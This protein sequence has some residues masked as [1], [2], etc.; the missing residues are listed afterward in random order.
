M[1]DTANRNYPKP[2][3]GTANVATEWQRIADALDLLD[4]DV[5][6]VL[7][8]L[9]TKA[10]LIH[11]HAIGDV[12]GLGAALASK[13]QG[14]HKHGLG[15][16]SDVDIVGAVLGQIFTMGENGKFVCRDPSAVLGA[17]N[18]PIGGV[19]GLQSALDAR[20]VAANDLS[21]LISAATARTNLGLGT[22]ATRTAGTASG[23]VPILSAANKLPALDGSALIN[24][25]APWPNGALSGLALSATTTTF[26][27][28]TGACRNE[29]AGAAQN[30]ALATTLTKSLAAWASGSA[31]GGLDT[32]TIAASTWYHVHLIRKTSDGALDALLS[33]SATA[34][35]M[36]SG[37]VARRRIGSIRTNASSQI[38][39]FTQFGDHFQWSV[40]VIDA[41]ITSLTS[42][43]RTQ[44]I[45]T[46]TGVPTLAKIGVANSKGS[47]NFFSLYVSPLGTTDLVPPLY[48]D[49][50]PTTPTTLYSNATN[51]AW[52]YALTEV[53]TDTSAQIRLR[54][55]TVAAN[56]KVM[57]QTFGWEDNRGR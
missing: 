23:N 39:P 16:L 21:D 54:T 28:A 5:A 50:A 22:A 48:T 51:N 36:P 55:S 49:M 13:A 6:N 38:N 26:S 2:G 56:D 9:L 29:D 53:L 57:V 24:L 52:E 47:V 1:A 42:S 17:H 10:A 12:T 7:A 14:D 31:N 25:S 44:V 43:A 8:A 34:P 40:P 46:P 4:A 35:T 41:I 45:S 32:G 3:P 19:T 18:H 20:L 15:D 11:P 27:I 37:Y 33:L 30:M